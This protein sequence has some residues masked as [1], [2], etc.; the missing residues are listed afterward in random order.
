M[1][2]WFNYVYIIEYIAGVIN[3][4]THLIS[5]SER[6]RERARCHLQVVVSIPKC[7][8]FLNRSSWSFTGPSLRGHSWPICVD[9]VQ[10][11]R[12]NHPYPLLTTPK[13]AVAFVNCSWRCA[14]V[15]ARKSRAF[16]PGAVSSSAAAPRLFVAR[17]KVK[18]KAEGLIDLVRSGGTTK[19]IK[20]TQ[21]NKVLLG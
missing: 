6:E 2:R 20:M 10:R 14:F 8:V 21:T 11:Y 18:H 17:N 9:P 13:V 15:H 16:P 1:I 3:V 5:W 19:W 12:K 4:Y 7:F